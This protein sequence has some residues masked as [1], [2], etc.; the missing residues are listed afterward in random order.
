[1][2]VSLHDFANKY[3]T[4]LSRRGKRM[5]E[6]YLYRLIREDIKGTNT[7]SLWF[8]YVLEGEKDKIFIVLDN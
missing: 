2:K 1:M 6:G 4:V 7:R 3:N 5:S 8:K